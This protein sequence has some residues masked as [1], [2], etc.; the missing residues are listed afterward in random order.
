MK[1]T[2]I[3]IELIFEK[4]LFIIKLALFIFLK[5][6]FFYIILLVVRDFQSRSIECVLRED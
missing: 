1:E 4:P 5:I 2:I 6:G 3:D